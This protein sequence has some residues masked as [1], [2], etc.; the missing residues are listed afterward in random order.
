MPGA[1]FAIMCCN[2]F[3]LHEIPAGTLRDLPGQYL[4]NTE[5]YASGA[6]VSENLNHFF[7]DKTD[8]KTD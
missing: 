4:N 7:S 2:N 3:V 1:S 6:R 5:Q 8:L